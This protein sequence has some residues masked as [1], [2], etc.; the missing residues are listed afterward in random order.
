[1]FVQLQARFLTLLSFNESHGS[2]F[3][4]AEWVYGDHTQYAAKIWC[5]FR[6]FFH[7]PVNAWKGGSSA[8]F[9][10]PNHS[11]LLLTCQPRLNS[12]VTCVWIRIQQSSARWRC[13]EAGPSSTCQSVHNSN[14]VRV[15]QPL[16]RP[17]GFMNNSQSLRHHLTLIIVSG[18]SWRRSEPRPQ[19]KPK[20]N[21]FNN[22][23]TLMFKLLRCFCFSWNIS[24]LLHGWELPALIL[25]LHGASRG[26]N[27]NTLK[28][29]PPS[30][31]TV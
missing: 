31:S 18:S 12:V 5:G 11:L 23:W 9:G 10:V 14:Y 26:L 22:L 28:H 19:P 7:S 24:V 15:M 1:M 20:R 21:V 4:S 29:P 27:K 17:V 25:L 13:K 6:S 2:L 30:L 3:S 16:E 8:L